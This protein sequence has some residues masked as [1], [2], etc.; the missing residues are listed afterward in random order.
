MKPAAA[1]PLVPPQ[2]RSHS[3]SCRHSPPPRE[4]TM[5]TSRLPAVALLAAF[6]VL[7]AC[8]E[9]SPVEAES[10]SLSQ[11]T[12]SLAQTATGPVFH[13]KVHD[14]YA[15]YHSWSWDGSSN[16]YVSIW[17]SRAAP[18]PNARAYLSI[19]GGECTQT[20]PEWWDYVCTSFGGE[21]T[22]RAA[23]VSGS[24]A[25]GLTLNTDLRGNP[26]FWLW[27]TDPGVVSVQWQR[28]GWYESRNS[29]S[30]ESRWGPYIN[31]QAGARRSSSATATGHALGIA[32]PESGWGEV[33]TGRG[34]S[35]SFERVTPN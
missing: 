26:D 11:A 34:V 14:D 8:H 31:R 6:A 32:L 4:T 30:Y 19:Y 25:S 15:S 10:A 33:H 21:G 1:A 17:V 9:A 3:D 7:P 5:N 27:G 18:G 35:L 29:G 12:P 22:I 28:T 13:M 23:D 20:G 24:F 16:R 2:A